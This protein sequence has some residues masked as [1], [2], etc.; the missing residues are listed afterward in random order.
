MFELRMQI[1]LQ[2]RFVIAR[3]WDV[4]LLRYSYVIYFSITYVVFWYV[5]NTFR[6]N[7]TIKLS[8]LVIV[9]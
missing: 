9:M 2:L 1:T 6:N 5:L 4:F 3:H 7:F 8:L